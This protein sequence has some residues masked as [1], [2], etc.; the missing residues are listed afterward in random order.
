MKLALK[1]FLAMIVLNSISCSDIETAKSVCDKFYTY[2]QAQKYDELAQFCSPKFFEQTTEKEMIIF[3]KELDIKMGKIKNF[4]VKSSE[5]F[6]KNNTTFMVFEYRVISENA[7][8]VDSLTLLLE[9]EKYKI[10]N[11]SWNKK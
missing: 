10:L 8:M 4:K 2:R 7:I 3:F 6:T 9:N 11:Y 1:I 5:V